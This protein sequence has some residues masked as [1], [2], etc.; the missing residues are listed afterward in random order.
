MTLRTLLTSLNSEDLATISVLRLGTQV[1]GGS[2]T[3]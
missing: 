2:G 1:K 3:F